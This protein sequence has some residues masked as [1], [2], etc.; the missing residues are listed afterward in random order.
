[1]EFRKPTE[2]GAVPSLIILG[3]IVLS[4]TVACIVHIVNTRKAM[5]RR[6]K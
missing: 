4:L 3:V 5:K 2:I 1:M 6:K